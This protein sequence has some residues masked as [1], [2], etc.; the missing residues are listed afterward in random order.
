MVRAPPRLRAFPIAMKAARKRLWPSCPLPGPA[1]PTESGVFQRRRAVSAQI[2]LSDSVSSRTATTPSRVGQRKC[3]RSGSLKSSSERS[4]FPSSPRKTMTL[5][6][7]LVT[8]RISSMASVRRAEWWG[9]GVMS[10]VMALFL[11][12]DV[13]YPGLPSELSQASCRTGSRGSVVKTQRSRDHSLT[14]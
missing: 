5:V 2:T 12:L 14:T 13:S 11:V 9:R 7:P 8:S 4:S 10:D 6:G 1:T 3:S